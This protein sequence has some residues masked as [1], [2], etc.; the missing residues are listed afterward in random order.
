[1]TSQTTGS[2]NPDPFQ[3]VR[4]ETRS[5][6]ASADAKATS[7][8]TLTGVLLGLGLVRDLPGQSQLQFWLHILSAGRSERFP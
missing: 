4:V 7:V 6:I 8:L 5:W 3:P 1:M 2:S